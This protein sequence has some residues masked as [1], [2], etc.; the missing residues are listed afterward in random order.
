MKHIPIIILNRDRLESTKQLVNL[1]LARKYTN[2]IILDNGSTYPPLLEWYSTCSDIRVFFNVA[3]DQNHYALHNLLSIQNEFFVS[4][5]RDS[6]YVFTDSDLI[7]H[8]SVPDNFIED[9]VALCTKYDK[10][11][12]GLGIHVDDM[13]ED[14]FTDA[15]YWELMK[16]M[17][18]YENQFTQT[19]GPYNVTEINS[20]DNPCVL[21]DAPIDTTFAVCRPNSMPIA[22]R[23]CIR[24]G[25][26][27]LSKHLP[28][29]YDINSY[30]VDE[31]YYLKHMSNSATTG[32][33][34]KVLKFL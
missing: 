17:K 13:H 9:L 23:N 10:D 29:Y 18:D 22:S 25:Y 26:P 24:T 3:V 4:L 27:Y 7:L 15:S 30:P 5:L 31:L 32:F 34:S 21:Y 16:F 28:F 1:L 33:S 2:I 12:V 14:L 20:A 6:W 8:D 19:G 11:K